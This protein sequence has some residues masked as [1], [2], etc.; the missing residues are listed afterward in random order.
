MFF[1]SDTHFF[2]ANIL[3]YEPWRQQWAADVTQ[4][5]EHLIA[6]WNR[7][8]K[9]DD[10]V[11]HL[12]DLALGT[13]LQVA[14]LRKRLNGEIFI[15]IGNH[16]R[17]EKQLNEMGFTATTSV[18]LATAGFMFGL[19]H[20]PQHFTDHEAD[21]CDFLLHGH[22]HGGDHRNSEREGVSPV[23]GA[24]LIDMGVDAWRRTTPIHLDELVEKIRQK[25]R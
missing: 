23:V 16:D 7:T 4:M 6:E 10:S 11:Y 8:V 25:M 15:T 13:R 9:P 24:K 22:W 2:H 19:R 12:G 21:N 17:S 1:F 14:E 20:N 5:N 18:A 3:K